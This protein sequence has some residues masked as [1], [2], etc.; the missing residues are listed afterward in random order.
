MPGPDGLKACMLINCTEIFIKPTPHVLNTSL[1]AAVF[2]KYGF[3]NGISTVTKL[4]E[5]SCQVVNL[6]KSSRQI[7]VIF[8]DLNKVFDKMNNGF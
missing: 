3:L 2:L 7:D 8:R 1:Y 6:F 4:L 5:F